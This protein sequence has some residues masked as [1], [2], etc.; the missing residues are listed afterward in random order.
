MGS[1]IFSAYMSSTAGDAAYT[2]HKGIIPVQ[3]ACWRSF[4]EMMKRQ[5]CQGMASIASTFKSKIEGFCRDTGMVEGKLPVHIQCGPFCRKH[6]DRRAL[7]MQI[8]T[9]LSKQLKAWAGPSG[10]TASGP[11][12]LRTCIAAELRSV[13]SAKFFYAFF[14]ELF[15]A[16]V[17]GIFMP[18][19]MF[20]ELEVEDVPDQNVPPGVGLNLIYARRRYV[21]WEGEKHHRFAAGV[22]LGRLRHRTA[23]AWLDLVLPAEPHEMAA[24]FVLHRLRFQWSMR[25]MDRLQLFGATPPAMESIGLVI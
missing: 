4:L 7:M 9:L 11:R 10:A 3:E 14:N 21:K 2:K 16:G 22:R 5:G 15:G 8:K 6:V 18:T 25:S 19:D 24:D 1:C 17:E 13:D 23:D 12:S 20:L